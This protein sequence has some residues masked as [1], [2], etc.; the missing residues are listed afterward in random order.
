MPPT[1]AGETN[2]CATPSTGIP[3][4]NGTIAYYLEKDNHEAIGGNPGKINRTSR[5]YLRCN[6]GSFR[7]HFYLSPGI[8]RIPQTQGN[9]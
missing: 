9:V 2:R 6:R 3:T 4:S 7:S 8:S 5:A 1:K